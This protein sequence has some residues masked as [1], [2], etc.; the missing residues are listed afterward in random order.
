MS[1]SS[2]SPGCSD[3]VAGSSVCDQR[4]ASALLL[5]CQL[6]Q[7]VS[8]LLDAGGGPFGF[9]V[10][11]CAGASAD[12]CCQLR[13]DACLLRAV[14]F[15]WLLGVADRLLSKPGGDGRCLELAGMGFLSCRVRFCD[16]SSLRCV[17]SDCYI[18]R[19]HRHVKSRAGSWDS[20]GGEHI[21][22]S[23]L[24]FCESS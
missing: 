7:L 22:R 12:I 15:G 8:W 21:S 3:P 24:C 13:H 18:G 20:S 1:V 11:I 16:Q 10:S 23:G 6:R 19:R 5:I 9:H 17:S 14:R 4:E 2:S